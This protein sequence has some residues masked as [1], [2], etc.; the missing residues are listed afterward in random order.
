MKLVQIY[1]HHF[2]KIIPHIYLIIFM[3]GGGDEGLLKLLF[4]TNYWLIGSQN[5]CCLP[6]PEMW[7]WVVLLLKI[8]LSVVLSISTCWQ[9]FSLPIFSY[10][11]VTKLVQIFWNPFEKILLP[12]SHIIYMSGE[13]VIGW[14]KLLSQTNCYLFGLTNICFL[15]FPVLCLW[16]VLLLKRKIISRISIWT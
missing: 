3:S 7:L 8:R 4:Y 16:V 1:W 9:H 15:L 13:D 11:S 10:L 12:I 14:L 2:V 6:F 5:T